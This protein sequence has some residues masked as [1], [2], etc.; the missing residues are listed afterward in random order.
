MIFDGGIEL[1]ET[2]PQSPHSGD[3]PLYTRGPWYGAHYQAG[4]AWPA[5]ADEGIGPYGVRKMYRYRAGQ[6]KNDY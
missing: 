3:S 4:I 2:I 1:I 5:R 6:G